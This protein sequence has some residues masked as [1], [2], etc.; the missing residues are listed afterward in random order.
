MRKIFYLS[1]TLIALFSSFSSTIC[2]QIQIADSLINVLNTQKLTPDQ[3]LVLYSNICQYLTYYDNEKILVYA[4]KGLALAEKVNDKDMAGNF[5]LFMGQ[6]QS[7]KGNYEQGLVCFEKALVLFQDT[8]NELKEAKVNTSIATCIYKDQLKYE[9][10]L[11]YYMKVLPIFKKL[12]NISGILPIFI[13]VADI[14][15]AVQNYDQAISYLEQAIPLA[16]ALNRQSDLSGIYFSLGDIY[17]LKQEYDKALELELKAVEMAHSLGFDEMEA[18]ALIDLAQIYTYGF[19]DYD[20]AEKDLKKAIT[21]LEQQGQSINLMIARIIL[22]EIFL[23]Q[24]RYTE[25]EAL[26]SMVYEQDSV[27]VRIGKNAAQLIVSSNIFLGNK[28]KAEYFFGKY[29]GYEEQSNKEN[30]IN[31]LSEMEVKFETEKKELRIAA[32]E[33]E[34]ILYS[35]LSITVGVLL[36][37]LLFLFIFRHRWEIAKRKLAE[38]QIKQLEQEKQ[39]VAVQSVL[40]GETAE[41]TRLARDLHDGLG[42]MLSVVKL[43]LDDIERLQDARDMLNLSITELRRV[44]HHMMPESLFRDGLKV[45]L[46]DFCRSVPNAKFHYFG[47]EGRLNDRIELLIYRCAHELVNNAIKY[48]NASTINVQIVR[49]ATQISLTVEDDGCGFDP[50]TASGMGLENLRTRVAAYNGKIH[51]FSSLG[52]GTEALVEFALNQVKNSTTKQK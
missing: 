51:L 6:A 2:A 52:K 3:Q 25:S 43:N 49:D 12:E 47:D 1:A 17:L 8:K 29:I 5:Y 44:A 26:A 14:Y 37:A 28:D 41:R 11:K 45:S 48:A 50:E 32:L 23:D 7:K 13:N 24:E 42:G 22:A 18:C 31:S 9:E 20:K 39:I 10:S 19:K 36:L 38:Q 46:A 15:I 4:E 40:D 35:G 30:L 33:K 21:L 16:E 27:D 34:K